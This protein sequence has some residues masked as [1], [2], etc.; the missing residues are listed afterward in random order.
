MAHGINLMKVIEH[1][2]LALAQDLENELNTGCVLGD[3]R[4]KLN[5]LAVGRVFNKLI[6]QPDLFDATTGDDAT[7]IH[8]VQSVL[9]G[10]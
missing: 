8:I 4:L 6:G 5:L 3:R 2:M 7:V 1:G 9:N 10:G